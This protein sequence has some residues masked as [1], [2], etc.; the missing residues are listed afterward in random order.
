MIRHKQNKPVPLFPF[1]LLQLR[2]KDLN[3]LSLRCPVTWDL[4]SD[5]FDVASKLISLRDIRRRLSRRFRSQPTSEHSGQLN[6]WFVAQILVQ[7]FRL[8]I[9]GIVVDGRVS[10]TAQ[11]EDH[12]RCI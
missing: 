11:E 9:L 2:E 7:Q 12:N 10:S 1:S 5:K 8:E 3:I 6:P 4:A